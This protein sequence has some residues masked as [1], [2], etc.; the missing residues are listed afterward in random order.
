MEWKIKTSDLCVAALLLLAAVEYLG[1][2]EIFSCTRN[3]ELHL[4]AEGMGNPSF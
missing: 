4:G 1:T 3:R 2:V